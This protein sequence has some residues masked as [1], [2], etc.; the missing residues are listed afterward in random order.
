MDYIF[1]SGAIGAKSSNLFKENEYHTLLKT[2]KG[3][4]LKVLRDFGYGFDHVAT[5]LDDVIT[6]EL[7]KTKSELLAIVPDHNI[8]RLW[9]LKYDLINIKLIVK[10]HLFLKQTNLAYDKAATIKPDELKEALVN[11]DF[12]KVSDLNKELLQPISELIKNTKLT[13]QELSFKIDNLVYQYIID[14]VHKLGDEAFLVYLKK[15]VDAN[16]LITL[17]R[18]QNIHL[19]EE[20]L[21]DS[22]IKAG[23]VSR[24]VFVNLYNK[25]FDEQADI[26]K[27]HY[28][29]EVI[30]ALHIYFDDMNLACLQQALMQ[31]ILESLTNY[32]YDTFSSGPLITYLVKKE[33]EVKNVRRLYFDKDVEMSSLLKY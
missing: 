31:D 23:N 33:F 14:T 29:N 21:K 19:H 27:L 25:R 22:L 28:S 13:S 15:F 5:Y 8:I 2:D 6:N 4:Y 10:N 20:V 30:K 1:A 11:N 26:L 9:F 7:I 16:N 18:A 17:F 12:D 24:D 3:E 32:N